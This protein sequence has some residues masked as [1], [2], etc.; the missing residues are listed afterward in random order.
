MFLQR[1]AASLLSAQY[2]LNPFLIDPA[3][4]PGGI[5]LTK[6][7]RD[8]RQIL[9][10]P[11]HD[12]IIVAGDTYTSIAEQGQLSQKSPNIAARALVYCDV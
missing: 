10:V 7:V 9:G 4:S 5:S 3:R 1:D 11:L 12:H 6:Q 2:H 8:T